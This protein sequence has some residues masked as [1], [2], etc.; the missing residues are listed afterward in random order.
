MIDVRLTA[1]N[2]EDST[3][4]PVPCNTRGELLTVAPVIEAIPNDV[5]IQGDL[6]VTGLINGSIGAG[7]PGPPGPEGPEGPQGPQGDGVPLPYGT[8]N[9]VLQILNGVPVWQQLVI[10]EPPIVGPAAI[11]SNVDTV[12]N[13][14]D[15]N[16]NPVFPPDNLAYLTDLDSWGDPTSRSLAGSK[17]DAD[18]LD[19]QSKWFEF[20]FQE[21]FGMVFKLNF[22][23]LYSNPQN[24]QPQKWTNTF[25]CT[26]ENVPLL[27]S[28]PT[29]WGDQGPNRDIW[30]NS[31]N[32]W[33]INRDISSAKFGWK[34]RNGSSNIKQVL[35][36]G[37]TLEDPGTY[38]LKNQV[39]VMEEVQELRFA[40]KRIDSAY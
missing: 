24:G 31:Y 8:E 22:S 7:E 15:A 27:T 32:I 19:D 16:G 23:I 38:A 25:Q 35:F 36:R 9:D 26:D 12:G 20:T 34:L 39:Q 11:W 6:T 13:C 5:E 18:V 14:T 10:P 37:W 4:V 33:T 1:T 29:S 3:L 2:P 30:V 28:F 21:A 17:Q 40:L